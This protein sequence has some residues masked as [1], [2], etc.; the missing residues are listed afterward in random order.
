MKYRSLTPKDRACPP[1]TRLGVLAHLPTTPPASVQQRT[2]HPN[3]HGLT[4]RPC[5]LALTNPRRRLTHLTC[6]FRYAIQIP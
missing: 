1:L 4:L 2:P 5:F 6:H 3:Y